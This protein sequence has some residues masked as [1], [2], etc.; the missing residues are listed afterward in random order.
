MG[1][2]AQASYAASKSGLFGL[3]KTLAREAAFQLK[4]AGKLEHD[5][6]GITVDTGAPGFIVTEMLEHIPDS[7]VVPC[8]ATAAGRCLVSRRCC[9]R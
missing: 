2:V 3:T 4:R 6:V 1:N 9:W 7:R 5:G 8:Q